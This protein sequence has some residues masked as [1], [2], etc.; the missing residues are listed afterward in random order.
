MNSD[1]PWV[2]EFYAPW[3][4]HCKEMRN[5][6]QQF[7]R[8]LKK[9]FKVGKLDVTVNHPDPIVERIGI[10]G[11]PSIKFFPPGEKSDKTAKTFKGGRKAADLIEWAVREKTRVL[12]GDEAAMKDGDVI[13]LDNS[14][15]S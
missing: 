11:Y 14:N 9:T 4:K 2:V 6:F 8:K 10:D 15:L 3:C 7:A 13:I 1:E 5:D 12:E